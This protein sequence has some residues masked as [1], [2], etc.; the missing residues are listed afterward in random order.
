MV[1]KFSMV[2]ELSNVYPAGIVNVLPLIVS[3]SPNNM[4]N[5]V[6]FVG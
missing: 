6:M 4:K 3:V 5:V 2:P 1:P